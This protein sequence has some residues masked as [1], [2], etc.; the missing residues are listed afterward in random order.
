MGEDEVAA[1]RAHG[2]REL[3]HRSSPTT[4]ARC[5]TDDLAS[6]IANARLDGELAARPRHAR[7]L[8]DHRHRRPR[9]HVE[10]DRR[11]PA[12][13]D[14]VPRSARAAAGAAG[15][16]RPGGRRDHPLRVAGEA[17]LPQR[18]GHRSRCATSRSSPAT[19]CTSRTRR[20]TATRRC[21]PIP[22]GSTCCART[23]RATSPSASAATSASARTSP[24]S[25]SAPSSSELLGRL[26]HVELAGVPTWTHAYFVEGP[27]SIPIRYTV[28]LN[29]HFG[30]PATGERAMTVGVVTGAASGMGRACIDRLRGTVDELLA[31]DLRAPDLDGTVGVAC[32]VSDP[33]AVRALAARVGRARSVPVAGARRRACRRPWP[34]RVASSTSTWSAPRRCSTR[35][36]RW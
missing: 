34:S 8:R 35:S 32:D 1:R 5:P 7:P 24:G 9:H 33:D 20:R 28:P 36:S 31:V 25:R 27:K 10:R 17:L 14:R 23:R 6:V 18:A 4:A 16:D 21:S 13:A 3:L 15:A 22:T 19:C 26:D 29:R 2:L 11:R 12:R 30:A